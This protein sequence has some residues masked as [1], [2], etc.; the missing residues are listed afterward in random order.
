MSLILNETKHSKSS[1]NGDY[2]S[3]IPI[4]LNSNG[5]PKLVIGAGIWLK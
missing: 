2:S 5:R 4:G 3:L 1:P